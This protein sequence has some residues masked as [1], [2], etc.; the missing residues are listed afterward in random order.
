[1]QLHFFSTKSSRH[2]NDLVIFHYRPL[3]QYILNLPVIVF[4]FDICKILLNGI[5]LIYMHV[6]FV[7][8]HTHTHL[9][10]RYYL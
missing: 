5:R 7:H 10:G 4:P 8:T 9:E 2:A 1:M 3:L 6:Q